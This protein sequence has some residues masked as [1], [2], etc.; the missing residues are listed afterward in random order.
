M[1]LLQKLSFSKLSSAAVQEFFLFLKYV[2]SG[3][4]LEPLMIILYYQQ[5][6]SAAVLD[7]NYC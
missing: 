5:R 6:V 2:I 3:S 4:Y 1:S 7:M